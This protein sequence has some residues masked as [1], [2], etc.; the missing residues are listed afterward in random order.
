MATLITN[1]QVWQQ[2]QL[3]KTNLL[4]EQG[5]IKAIDPQLTAATTRADQVI[6]AANH[7][8]SPGLVDVHVHLREPGQTAKETIAT[9]TAAA[10]HGGFTTVGAMPNVDPVPDTPERVAAMVA[11]NRTKAKVHVAQYA[12]ITT[13]R[14]GDQLIDFAAVKQAGAF[15]V[16]NDGSGVQTANT[17]YQA[18][19]GAAKAG[20]PLAAHV[21]DD[22]L[23]Q[24]GVMNAGPVAEQLGLPGINNVS[25][26]AQVAR[27]V[28]LA[29]ASGV[30]YHVC[31]VSTAESVRVVRDAK[32]AGI[33]VTCEVS[34][35]HLLLTDEDIT[36]DNPM[37][38]MNPPLRSPRDRAALIAGLLDGTIDFIATDHAPHTDAE[39]AGSM[40]TAAFGITGI[41]TAFATMYT[42]LVKTR[43]IS[44]GQLINLMSTKPAE[45]FG[46]TAAGHLAVGEAADLAI[47]DLDHQYQIQA[48]DMLSKGHNSPFIGWS[49]YG[50][51][52]MTLVDGQV[53]YRKDQAK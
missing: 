30:H 20:L 53:A 38:K 48:A 51:V 40:R 2:T 21:E 28:M 25:E 34:P 33:N 44:L 22:S 27:D 5:K 19:V 24:G 49:V 26:A 43:L 32:R 16:S 11:A 36:M 6:D 4:I 46:L 29:E 12:S 13:G 31:H 15:A 9:G 10:A 8:V 3:V 7:F 42:A 35:H 45:L 39:K 52:L 17:M 41:E 1:A 47:I 50:D 18:M 14:A 37:L 23:Y